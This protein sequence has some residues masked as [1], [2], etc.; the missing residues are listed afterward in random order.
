MKPAIKRRPMNKSQLLP[1]P[2]EYLRRVQLRHHIALAALNGR[3]AAAEQLALLL[4]TVQIA[5]LLRVPRMARALAEAESLAAASFDALEAGADAID[6]SGTGPGANDAEPYRRA[7][8]AIEQ[9][10]ARLGGGSGDLLS[11]DERLDLERLM[12][13]FDARLATLP[14]QRYLDAQ[15]ELHHYVFTGRSPIPAASV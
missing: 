5:Y 7:E 13:A 14:T 9:C 12:T 8:Q 10:Y 4:S 6:V 1:L 3:H 2:A 11:A 15:A